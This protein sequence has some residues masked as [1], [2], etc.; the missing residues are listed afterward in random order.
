MVLVHYSIEEDDCVH[1]SV[2]HT[3]YTVRVKGT[4]SRV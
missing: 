3:E 2:I 4:A 1:Y